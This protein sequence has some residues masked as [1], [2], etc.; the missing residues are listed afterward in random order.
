RDIM[1]HDISQSNQLHV[2]LDRDRWSHRHIKT[3]STGTAS[4][5]DSS[6]TEY[7]ESV[8]ISIQSI[9]S[10]RSWSGLDRL[11]ASLPTFYPYLTQSYPHLTHILSYS[12]LTHTL[13]TSHP[14]LIQILSNRS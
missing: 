6:R 5:L 7:L 4:R 9:R 1:L 13:S 12:H 11:C 3:E 8:W 14:H 2:E 10:G